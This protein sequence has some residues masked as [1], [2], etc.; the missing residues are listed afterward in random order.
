[1][2]TLSLT[3]RLRDTFGFPAFRASQQA[4]CEAAV[5]GRDVLLVM[6]TGAGKSLCY[7]LPALAREGTALVISPLIA[8]M[9]DQAGKLTS[10]GL[11]VGRIHSGL[12]RDH[13]RQVC[14]EYLE[15]TLQFLF[16]APERF[17]VPGFGAMLA[18][19]KLSLIAIDEAHCISQWGHDF[20]PDYRNLASHLQGLRPAPVI[21]LTA[22]ATP[23]VQRDIV[24]ELALRE[25]AQFIQGFRRTNLAIEVVEVSKPRRLE[26]AQK[27]LS[28]KANR[29]AIIYAPSRK[30]AET[31]ASELGSKFSAATYHAGLD[32]GTRERVQRA[33]LSGELEVVVATI[34]FGMGIDKADV[35]TVLHMAMPASVES[36]YQEIGRA[37]RDGKPARTVLM[38]S[39]ADRRMHDFFLE[40]DYPPAD[41]LARIAAALRSDPM[42]ADDLRISLKLDVDVFG[43]ALDKLLAQGAAAIDFAGNVARTGDGSP[44]WR[45][46]YDTQ[47]NFRRGQIDAM[48][49]FASGAECRMAALIRHFGD[50]SD[51]SRTC[52]LCDFCSPERASAQAFRAPGNDELREMRR[53]LRALAAAPSGKSTGKL[54]TELYPKGDLDRKEMDALLDAL[55]RAGY[56]SV[57]SANFTAEDGRDIAYRKASLTH[58]GREAADG[59]AL[60]GLQMRDAE[61][62]NAGRVRKPAQSKGKAAAE[63]DSVPLTAEQKKID[64]ALRTWRAAEAKALGKPAFVVF[65]DRTLRQLAL[66]TPATLADLQG[67]SGIGAAKAERWGEAILALV[68]GSGGLAEEVTGRPPQSTRR[69]PAAVETSAL[70]EKTPLR[71]DTQGTKPATGVES[72]SSHQTLEQALK[73]W[74]M[75]EAKRQATT[76]FKL[77]MDQTIEHIAAE[78]PESVNALREISGL[79]A[80][81]VDRFGEA[82]CTVIAQH[83]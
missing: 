47:V 34:A 77:L 30:D 62:V 71:R 57:E 45:R 3:D 23:Q 82:I 42:H 6:P 40:R 38:Y 81:W 76:P 64:A 33:F 4:V 75:Q 13:S 59:E 52:G 61:A 10:L 31:L 63:M 79:R 22:T 36:F 16:I 35:R 32:P 8:L 26:L 66:D 39:F 50:A 49:R 9:D 67:I 24:S 54:Y 11:R 18:K 83:S 73:V 53:L 55:T 17:R 41:T 78:K 5:A 51:S 28:D 68:N 43:P 65:G 21:A 70:A 74:R 12:D 2:A 46:S 7:Q 69:A 80:D 72:A 20:R 37:G 44:A 29:P 56:T 19:R 27:L 15:G 60:A 14:R 58:E 1:M 25:P 48:M